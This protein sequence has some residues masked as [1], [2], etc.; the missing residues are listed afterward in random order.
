MGNLVFT[1]C[2]SPQCNW[3]SKAVDAVFVL[4]LMLVQRLS[5]VTSP[6]PTAPPRGLSFTTYSNF[7]MIIV[8]AKSQPDPRAYKSHSRARWKQHAAAA[9]AATVYSRHRTTQTT[10]PTRGWLRTFSSTSMDST[11]NSIDSQR[12]AGINDVFPAVNAKHYGS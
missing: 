5:S 2:S 12:V 9:A 11:R 7:H 6:V 3:F 10:L 4:W 1:F 8:I